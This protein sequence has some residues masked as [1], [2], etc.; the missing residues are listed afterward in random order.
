MRFIS[1]NVYSNERAVSKFFRELAASATP[2][3]QPREIG[4]K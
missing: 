4:L 2:V 1:Y 3:W